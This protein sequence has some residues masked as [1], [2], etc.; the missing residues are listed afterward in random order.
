MDE[1]K[2]PPPPPPPSPAEE[3]PIYEVEEILKSRRRNGQYQYYLRW[4]GFDESYNTWE[5]EENLYSPELLEEYWS[6]AGR[7][8]QTTRTSKPKARRKQKEKTPKVKDEPEECDFVPSDE[9]SKKS[10]GRK[11]QAKDGNEDWEEPKVT[12][13]RTQGT[14][15][16]IKD[17]DLATEAPV[18]KKARSNKKTSTAVQVDV[19]N[20]SA[21]FVMV[22]E[23]GVGTPAK[24]KDD[25]QNPVLQP[26]RET[27]NDEPSM[28]LDLS[29]NS[30]FSAE[31]QASSTLH[32]KDIQ[33]TPCHVLLPVVKE[34]LP[35]SKLFKDQHTVSQQPH[36]ENSNPLKSPGKSNPKVVE[37]KLNK[38]STVDRSRF[39]KKGNKVKTNT[40]SET[41]Q[42]STSV[43]TSGIG[44]FEPAPYNAAVMEVSNLPIFIPSKSE[45]SMALRA[46]TSMLVPLTRKCKT[47]PSSEVAIEAL[48]AVA[49]TAVDSN[50]N[51]SQVCRTRFSEVVPET[52]I[53]DPAS[54][55]PLALNSPKAS[56]SNVQPERQSKRLLDASSSL[57]QPEHQSKRLLEASIS[58]LVQPELQSKR[59]LEASSSL[60][61]PELQSKKL[62]EASSSL[63]QPEHQSKRLLEASSSLVQPERQSKRLSDLLVKRPP[64]PVPIQAPKRVT[65]KGNPDFF[66]MMLHRLEYI[67][68]NTKNIEAV[69]FET[70]LQEQQD[71]CTSHLDS[72]S[73][74]QL[75]L[76]EEDMVDL[77]LEELESSQSVPAPPTP[78]A[79]Q[80]DK[81]IP[82][83]SPA[84]KH[85]VSGCSARDPPQL[86][87]WIDDHDSPPGLSDNP[88]LQS[89]EMDSEELHPRIVE[90]WGEV[91][92]STLPAD[93]QLSVTTTPLQT[94]AWSKSKTPEMITV[95]DNNSSSTSA[96]S[97]VEVFDVNCQQTGAVNPGWILHDVFPW[98]HLSCP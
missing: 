85:A 72:E 21:Q 73:A 24:A 68:K 67:A 91:D 39:G 55:P 33:C 97:I 75:S 69:S 61:Q 76:V 40:E 43:S 26:F 60:V 14:K 98:N 12:K 92:M 63:V 62:L 9:T 28:L 87:R 82:E 5:P 34:N 37:F 53:A 25:T 66:R 54:S 48:D 20:V 18:A 23:G 83:L 42:S 32:A 45:S 6:K 10:T 58:S 84:E 52:P 93:Q 79:S 90:C 94:S 44:N 95:D 57:V 27:T 41:P 3:E 36:N 13:K 80:K 96:S 47:R 77:Y 88:P 29:I 70:D 22:R 19:H 8:K 86:V 11:K 65:P 71:E 15:R 74:L 46:S 35:V 30:T 59:L 81:A 16:K 4:K 49:D 17:D 64:V 7:T 50:T 56:S 38:K 51:A 89:V 78:L 2:E 31:P 1:V